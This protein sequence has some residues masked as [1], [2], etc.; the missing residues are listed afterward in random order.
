MSAKDLKIITYKYVIHDTKQ[1]NDIRIFSTKN[2]NEQNKEI[3]NHVVRIG[4][5]NFRHLLK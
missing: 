2:I 4:S 1:S 3:K 5:D